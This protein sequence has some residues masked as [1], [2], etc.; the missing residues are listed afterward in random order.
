M[1]GCQYDFSISLR[2]VIMMITL[3]L[4]VSKYLCDKELNNNTKKH[5]AD[6]YI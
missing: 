5:A 1:S 6:L 2:Q 3:R 4:D